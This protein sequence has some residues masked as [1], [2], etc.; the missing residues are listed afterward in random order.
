[1]R[2][3]LINVYVG[4]DQYIRK[5]ADKC[6]RKGADKCIRKGLIN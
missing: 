4:T 2:R 1:M 5:E 3:G 6:I